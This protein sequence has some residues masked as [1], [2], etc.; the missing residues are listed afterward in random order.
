MR[1][2]NRLRRL[3]RANLHQALDGAEN[4]EMMVEYLLL[5]MQEQC[6]RSRDAVADAM[7]S[8]Q[9]MRQVAEDAA[10][11]AVRW[12]GRARLALEHGEEELA[13]EALRRRAAAQEQ[14]SA[15]WQN[16]E[17][18][19][20]TVH[21]LREGLERLERRIA[22]A[23]AQRAQLIAQQAAARA[24]RHLAN[25]TYSEPGETFG[26]F[27]RFA[28]KLVESQ[29]RDQARLTISTSHL[30]ERFTAAEDAASLDRTLQIMREEM[31]LSEPKPSPALESRRDVA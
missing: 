1:L 7:A 8:E 19:R 15:Y 6:A 11:E 17:Q 9:R 16:Y 24:Q 30:E 21:R 25:A 5:E 26:E 22:E 18:Q 2:L 4:P 27:R 29:T 12:E 31:P 23:D 10:Q 3:L 20:V 13:R 28:T 14:A